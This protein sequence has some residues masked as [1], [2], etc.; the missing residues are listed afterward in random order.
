MIN[1]LTIEERFVKKRFKRDGFKVKK[2]DV[3]NKYKAPDFKLLKSNFACLVEVKR[4]FKVGKVL[5]YL[6]NEAHQFD[7]S[8]AI[9]DYF[10]ESVQKFKEHTRQNPEDK[11]LPYILTFVTPF[12]IDNEL[13]W[14]DL[15]YKKYPLI[16]AVFIPK[17]TDPYAKKTWSMELKELEKF[18]ETNKSKIESQKRFV[19]Q[20]IKNPYAKKVLEI[21]YFS[22][23]GEAL[24]PV[25]T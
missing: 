14:S 3:H 13:K 2:I 15:P 7:S 10:R 6:P 9:E 1:P 5:E 20:V 22:S 19:W 18:I 16:S 24:Y 11:N 23:S 21:N 17:T 4:G 12:W 8:Y 25:K